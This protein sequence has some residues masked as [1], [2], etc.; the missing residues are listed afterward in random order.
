[1]PEP[2]ALENDLADR[3][4]GLPLNRRTTRSDQSESAQGQG[5][6]L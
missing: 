1:M 3:I 2:M 6:D 5:Q 4:K